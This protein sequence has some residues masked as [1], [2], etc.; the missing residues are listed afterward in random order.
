M[1][2][3]AGGAAANTRDSRGYTALHVAAM[4]GQKVAAVALL[5]GGAD[6]NAKANSGDT[7]LT[8][9]KRSGEADMMLWLQV[10]GAH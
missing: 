3:L 4:C 8:P 9:A 10:K 1:A 7:P 5:A 2:L 6:L